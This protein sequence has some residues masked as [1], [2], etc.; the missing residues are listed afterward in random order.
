MPASGS[1]AR[2]HARACAHLCIAR[3]RSPMLP[4]HQ[5]PPVS[6]DRRPV[7][8]RQLKKLI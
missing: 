4:L 1:G 3:Q 5:P 7:P 2:R 8:R 6:A